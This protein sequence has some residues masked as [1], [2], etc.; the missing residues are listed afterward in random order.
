MSEAAFTELTPQTLVQNINGKTTMIVFYASWCPHCKHYLQSAEPGRLKKMVQQA[1]L[2]KKIGLYQFEASTL[3]EHVT[4]AHNL[5][6][7]AQGRPV[8]INAFPTF[9]FT[10]NTGPNQPLRYQILD[11]QVD[12]TAD[13]QYAA[14]LKFHQAASRK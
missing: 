5:F 7:D 12:R 9:V 14:L 8:E 6:K 2:D 11:P 3:P 10:S 4:V 1:G 13:A